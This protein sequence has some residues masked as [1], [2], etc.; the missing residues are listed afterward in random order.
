MR[1]D[2]KLS[3]SSGLDNL[4]TRLDPII[5]REFESSLAGN[6]WTWILEELDRIAGRPH[7]PYSTSDLQVQLKM[8]TRRLGNLGF[9]FDDHRQTVG[10]LGR[11]LT[12]VRNARAH[13]DDFT[14]LDAWRAHDYCVRLLEHFDDGLG[15]IKANELRHEA[16]LAYVRQV[17]IAPA[18]INSSKDTE[19]EVEEP[20]GDDD[21]DEPGDG[22]EIAPDPSVFDRP[23]G[24]K[25]TVVGDRRLAFEPWTPVLVGGVETL[26]QLPKMAAKQKVRAVAAVVVD[27]EGPIHLDRLAQLVAASFGVRK[28]HAK[29]AA[30]IKRQVKAAGLLVD[31]DGFVWPD[32]LDPSRWEEF[33]PNSSAVDRPFWHISPVEI[34]NARRFITRQDAA[35]DA[36]TIDSATLRTFGRRRRTRRIGS[37]LAKAWALTEQ[38]VVRHGSAGQV[39][40][41]LEADAH[42]AAGD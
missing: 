20:N 7:R 40:R 37:H 5:L 38:G 28:L 8:F 26:D 31:H 39:I 34:A 6:P 16:L 4:A 11:E 2:P 30:Q 22:G 15:L 32:G 33:R 18:P 13:G 12:I 25:I 3:V 36:A 35:A 41:T 14:P 29:R 42:A 21:E 17:G 9:P 23:K 19:R 10:T 1:F 24:V 27:A